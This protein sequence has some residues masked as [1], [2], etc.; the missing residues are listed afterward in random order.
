MLP[1]SALTDGIVTLRH[2][3]PDDAEWYVEQ[4]R[5][6][7][8]QRWTNEPPD[9]TVAYVRE[10]IEE[11]LRTRAHAGLAIT[12]AAT[13]ELLGN[14]GLAPGDEPGTGKLAYSVAPAARGRGVATRAV[15][16]LVEYA[17]EL[18]LDRVELWAH[19]GNV[20]SQRVA[21][22]AGLHRDRVEPAGKE[23]KGETW[24]VVWY[25][26]DRP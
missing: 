16:L 7:E 25:A 10:V 17:W 21:E 11:L 2:W 8:I 19:V 12:D 5:D 14:A 15:R 23:V 22:R 1:D 3:H 4:S 6:A 18:G 26:L 13:G 9:L 24:D 20:G